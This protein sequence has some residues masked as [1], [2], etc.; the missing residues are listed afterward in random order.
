VPFRAILVSPKAACSTSVSQSLA[1]RSRVSWPTSM[2]GKSA[3]GQTFDWSQ[4]GFAGH[5]R[6]VGAFPADQ[7]LLDDDRG[8]VAAGDGYWATFWP[9]GPPPITTSRR[10]RH[11]A[12][13]RSGFSQQGRPRTP[14]HTT[15]TGTGLS[16]RR[17]GRS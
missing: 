15:A 13:A 11:K 9:G 10:A 7:F 5:A 8:P 2:S 1:L 6:P 12:Q 16:E 17:G 4:E 14:R 3:F